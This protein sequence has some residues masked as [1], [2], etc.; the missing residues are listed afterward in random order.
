[1]TLACRAMTGGFSA[2]GMTGTQRTRKQVFGKLELA[3]QSEFPL[4]EPG[5]LSALGLRFHLDVMILQERTQNRENLR[6]R[7]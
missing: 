5:G 1:M 2:A 3:D 6:T 7:K 4:A